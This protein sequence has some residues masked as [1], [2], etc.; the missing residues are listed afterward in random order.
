MKLYSF[1]ILFLLIVILTVS[2]YTA[3]NFNF[4]KKIPAVISNIFNTEEAVKINKH[5]T[6][7]PQKGIYTTVWISRSQK[8]IEKRIDLID[9][10]ELN[11]IIVDVKD[12]GV[13][14]D[15]Y[16]KNLVNKLHEK[17]IYTIARL[18]VFQ[19]NSQVENYPEWYFK[20]ADGSLWH[21]NRGWYFPNKRLTPVL[22]S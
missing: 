20:K 10:T 3:G 8:N 6:L 5:L 12:S 7:N 2:V 16:T 18:V 17:N 11:A 1:S 4:I 21:D 15:D 14:V 22:T 13:Y 19:D 9:R